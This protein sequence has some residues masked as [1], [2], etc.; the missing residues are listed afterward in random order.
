MSENKGT[1]HLLPTRYLRA[2]SVSETVALGKFTL[3]PIRLIPALTSPSRAPAL[4]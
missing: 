2:R 4:D 3:T 1:A